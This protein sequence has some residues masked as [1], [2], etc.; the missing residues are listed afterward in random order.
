MHSINFPGSG[1]I[2]LLD[3]D[4]E[5][6]I[7]SRD[8][9]FKRV[10]DGDESVDQSDPDAEI[11]VSAGE[12]DAP[13]VP[14]LEDAAASNAASEGNGDQG[15]DDQGPVPAPAV[16]GPPRRSPRFAD[17]DQEGDPLTFIMEDETFRVVLLV[18]ASEADSDPIS[19]RQAILSSCAPQWL[20]AM[21]REYASI[22][23][24]GVWLEVTVPDGSNLIGSKWVF[25]RKMDAAGS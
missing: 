6:L 13:P 23:R 9:V 19:Y 2:V 14:I 7:I 3:G 5:K 25:K 8:V 24:N 22:E 17:L 12:S 11:G 1:Y 15:S 16:P 10:I 20:E 18:A 4:A 21:A